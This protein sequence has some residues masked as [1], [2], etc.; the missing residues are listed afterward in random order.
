MNPTVDLDSVAIAVRVGAAL[1]AGAIIGI[2]RELKRK[3]AGLRTHALVSVGSAVVVL[4]AVGSTQGNADAVSRAIQGIITGI[5][6][7][8]AGVIMQYEAERRVEGLTTAASVWVA[9]GLGMAC[10]AGLV[11]LV[12]I[13]VIATVLILWG[14]EKIETWMA[15]RGLSTPP[16][17]GSTPRAPS[18]R[19]RR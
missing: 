9:A 18:N 15:Q 12:A 7:L 11:E 4:I 19:N 6:F 1:H 17:S 16:P 10:G 3:P 14:G 13:A 2:D 8:G 5:G